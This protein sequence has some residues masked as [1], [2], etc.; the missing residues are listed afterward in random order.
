MYNSQCSVSEVNTCSSPRNT[1]APA[2]GPSSV[3]T[4]PRI[5]MA[6]SSPD[7]VQAAMSGV[8]RPA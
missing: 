8:T 3:P 7:L 4:P 2:I 6:I 1:A 5:T